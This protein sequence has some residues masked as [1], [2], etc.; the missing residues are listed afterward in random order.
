MK[1]S[2]PDST[3]FAAHFKLSKKLCPSTEKEKGE[4]S[5]IPYSSII[6][7]L[8]YAIVCT[9]LDISHAVGVKKTPTFSVHG[10]GGGDLWGPA[11]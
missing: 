6:G 3:P 9:R 1:N 11:P 10:S 7:S 2:R 5:V 4:R 8:M